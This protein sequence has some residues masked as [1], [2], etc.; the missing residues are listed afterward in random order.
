MIVSAR[1]P[2]T[3]GFVALMFATP[4]ASAQTKAECLAAFEKGQEEQR[5]LHLRAARELFLSCTRALCSAPVRQDCAQHLEAV[6]RDTPTLVVGA[7]D[8]AGADVTDVHVFLDG[9]RVIPDAGGTVAVDPGP[10]TLRFERP[11]LAPQSYEVLV[12]TGERS[13]LVIATYP[14]PT[15]MSSRATSERAR[16]DAAPARSPWMYI[17]G[18]VGALALGSFAFFGISG[19]QSRS[20]LQDTCGHSCEA[21]RISDVRTKFVVADVSLAIGVV[22][23]AA[24]TFFFFHERPATNQRLARSFWK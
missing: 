7:R 20:E 16:N 13:R 4:V 24:A 12:R 14:A 18:G 21:D 11:P 8:A 17:T 2:A 10:H 9:M 22:S 5:L 23:L 3:F 19:I 15:P 1:C 6:V